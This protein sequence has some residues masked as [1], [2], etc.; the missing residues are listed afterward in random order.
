M[1]ARSLENLK[2]VY[3]DVRVRAMKMRQD[4]HKATGFWLRITRGYASYSDQLA[5]YEQGRTKPGPIVTNARPGLSMHNFGLAFDVCFVGLDPY[6]ETMA[7]MRGAEK[8]DYV[9]EVVARC[10]EGNGLVSGRRFRS[11]VDNPHAQIAYGLQTHELA[12]LYAF[13]G[14]AG[15][16]TQCDK[17]RGV[18]R[19]WTLESLPEQEDRNV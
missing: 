4:V 5:L 12:D 3:P 1:D 17:I 6:L 2:Y 16:W 15:V 14:L 7:K 10:A 11:R 13:S 18:D 19:E 9:W 8:A